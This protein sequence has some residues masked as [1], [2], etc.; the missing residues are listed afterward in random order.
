[1][2]IEPGM[3]TDLH[4]S[5]SAHLL[6]VLAE[7]GAEEFHKSAVILRLALRMSDMYDDAVEYAVC[8]NGDEHPYCAAFYQKLCALTTRGFAEGRGDLFTPAGP[9]YTECR[10]TE[11]GILLLRRQSRVDLPRGNHL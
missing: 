4:D 5:I 7:L 3:N 1:M 2:A 6:Q 8:G 11:N 9:R 10:I